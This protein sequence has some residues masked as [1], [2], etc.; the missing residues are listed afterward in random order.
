MIDDGCSDNSMQMAKDFQ[1]QIIKHPHNLGK[2]AALRSGFKQAISDKLDAVITID[3][4]GQHDPK[5]IPDIIRIFNK[6]RADIILGKRSFRPGDM[7]LDRIFSNIV[8]SLLISEAC[9]QWIPDS[10]C[11]FRLISTQVL[12]QIPL[13][14]NHYETETE[15]LIKAVRKKFKITSCPIK[16]TYDTSTSHIH[17]FRDT[18]RFIKILIKLMLE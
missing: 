9:G 7:P 5:Y 18:M 1:V 8:S 10:Q 12:K 4:D 16:I 15:I 2:G 13:R 3:G 17:R 6:T 14:T 11:G